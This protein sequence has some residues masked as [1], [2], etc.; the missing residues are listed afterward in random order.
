MLR[1][2][3]A[4]GFGFVAMGSYVSVSVAS[5]AVFDLAILFITFRPFKGVILI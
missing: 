4:A 1:R 2:A 3:M 5:V